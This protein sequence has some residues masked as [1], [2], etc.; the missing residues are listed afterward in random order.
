MPNSHPRTNVSSELLLGSLVQFEVKVLVCSNLNQVVDKNSYW[1]NWTGYCIERKVGK[2]NEILIVLQNHRERNPHS[3]IQFN[4]IYKDI[5]WFK[6]HFISSKDYSFIHWVFQNWFHLMS[7]LNLKQLPFN[8]WFLCWL[9]FHNLFMNSSLMHCFCLD[10]SEI[11]KL[12]D[13]EYD[14]RKNKVDKSTT[15]N[16]CEYHSKQVPI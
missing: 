13:S 8:Q 14:H 15:D 9:K 11:A 16:L 7:F 6:S 10:F 3:R 12:L 1:C 4:E 2:L 5:L